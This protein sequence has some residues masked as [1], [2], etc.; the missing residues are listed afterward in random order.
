MAMPNDSAQAERVRAESPEHL[1]PSVQG[2]QMFVIPSY[3]F[4]LS[5]LEAVDSRLH[6]LVSFVA[7]VTLAVPAVGRSVN[8]AVAFRSHWFLA[9]MTAALL[10]V[11]I[12]F[13]MRVWG[14]LA[15]PSPAKIYERTLHLSSWEFQ[16]DTIFFAGQHF[17]A[18]A[19][20]VNTKAN[21]VLAMSMLFLAELACLFLWF[22]LG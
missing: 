5:R 17:D 21:G 9:G 4:M 6:T 18:N 8:A 14:S 13:A 20:L 2:A 11:C 1:W 12:G 19:R 10:S 7:T 3:Q 22:A 15:L 16:R